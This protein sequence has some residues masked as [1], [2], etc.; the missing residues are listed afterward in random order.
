ML[1]I[2]AWWSH[3]ATFSV[4][5]RGYCQR[6]WFPPAV[7]WSVKDRTGRAVTP[8]AVWCGVELLMSASRAAVHPEPK[9]Q[10]CM[11]LCRVSIQ[12]D[13]HLHHNNVHYLEPYEMSFFSYPE[14]RYINVTN[15]TVLQ[16]F[17]KSFFFWALWSKIWFKKILNLFIF[18]Q[19]LHLMFYFS[20]F[21][22][23]GF[24]TF[25]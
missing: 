3:V 14:K 10:R 7:M 12:C 11:R 16:L 18:Y 21:H 6:G 1:V 24:I 8:L 23:N 25:E 19:I 9:T 13:F 2:V 22:F 20:G 5:P 15:Y 17:I 4:T